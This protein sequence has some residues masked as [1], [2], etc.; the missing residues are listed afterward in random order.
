MY[1]QIVTFL[2]KYKRISE[3]DLVPVQ[4]H[5]W[6]ITLKI[7][8]ANFWFYLKFLKPF[9]RSTR[10]NYPVELSCLCLVTATKSN[11]EWLFP[12][13]TKSR[14]AVCSVRLLQLSFLFSS[15][16]GSSCFYDSF[17]DDAGRFCDCCAPRWRQIQTSRWEGE[18]LENVVER[19]HSYRGDFK[20]LNWKLGQG[21]HSFEIVYKS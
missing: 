13:L 19:K 4:V 2:Q 6:A 5:R 14:I 16:R 20:V 3:L 9:F 1:W 8:R 18:I 21:P 7:I 15:R 11:S 17:G 12:S 10:K